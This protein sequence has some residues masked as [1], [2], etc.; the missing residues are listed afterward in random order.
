MS[1][2]TKTGCKHCSGYPA[3]IAVLDG[4][5]DCYYEPVSQPGGGWHIEQDHH[6]QEYT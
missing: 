3:G 5:D 2:V 4:F 1:T 6:Q